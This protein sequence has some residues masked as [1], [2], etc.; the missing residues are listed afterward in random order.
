MFQRQID[1]GQRLRLNALGGVHHQ[2]RA[3]AGRQRAGHFVG[4]VHMAG[5][6]DQVQDVGIAVLGLIRH[7]H[8]LRLDGDAALT[9]QIHGVEHLVAH[10]AQTHHARLF[11]QA[12]G[13]G[14]FTVVDV[15]NDAEI[16][17]HVFSLH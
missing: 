17:D 9:L 12:V 11:N 16:A 15:R 10:L 1:V 5:G 13:Q 4:K 7:A 6:V 8:G 3:V 2:D 14:G